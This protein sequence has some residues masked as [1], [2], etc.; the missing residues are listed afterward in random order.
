[1]PPQPDLATQQASAASTQDAL[2][3][4]EGQAGAAAG[5]VAAGAVGPV[6]ALIARAWV[7]LFGSTTAP[8]DPQTLPR[9]VRQVR[10][11]LRAVDGDPSEPVRDMLPDALELG[12][13]SAAGLLDVDVDPPDPSD[14]LAAD[15]DDLADVVD[16]AVSD[17]EDRL[18]AVRD[19]DGA[20]AVIGDLKAAEH[21]ADAKA[22]AVVVRGVSEGV[23]HVAEVTG[24]ERI[25][26]AEREGAC[27]EC[28]A[29]QGHVVA[30][31]EEFPGGLTFR[32]SD[33]VRFPDPI[34]GPPRHPHCRCHTALY[35]HEWTPEG[36]T[37]FQDALKRE[38]QRAVLRF[39]AGESEPALRRAADGLLTR[40]TRLP[41]S[42]Q[43]RAL[44]RI[45]AS[46]AASTRNTKKESDQ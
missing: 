4:L 28:L 35:R 11:A 22:R 9:F 5:A 20:T 40:G 38:A 25:W 21:R 41:K 18:T 10:V 14:D 46:E 36:E 37:S 31:G 29:Y 19:W 26:I 24:S 1:M 8:A 34:P 39:D 42:V 45:A 33:K 6:I 12:T 13:S 15:V 30:A 16:E 43:E 23:D 17:A 32:V 44:R 2:E 27:L 7:T 3:T